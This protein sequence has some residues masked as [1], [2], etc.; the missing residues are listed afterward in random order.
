[1]AGGW[2]PI[3]D[4]E[5]DGVTLKVYSEAPHAIMQMM[6]TQENNPDGY[7][8]PH[9]GS[10]K[11]LA[12][13]RLMDFED[14]DAMPK[15]TFRTVVHHPGYPPNKKLVNAA[16][17]STRQIKTSSTKSV[18]DAYFGSIRKALGG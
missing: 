8:I 12:W 1:M 10:R 6:G 15:P 14:S 13:F 4:V 5:P 17:Q 18:R 7:R 2:R 3:V 9:E 11:L 16:K